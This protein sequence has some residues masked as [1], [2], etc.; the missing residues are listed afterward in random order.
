MVEGSEGTLSYEPKS[1]SESIAQRRADCYNTVLKSQHRQDGVLFTVITN[2]KTLSWSLCFTTHHGAVSYVPD[3]SPKTLST[4]NDPVAVVF[5]HNNPS[6]PRVPTREFETMPSPF[7]A[8]SQAK[9]RYEARR[10]TYFSAMI[11]SHIIQSAHMTAQR[12]VRLSARNAGETWY[13]QE[14]VRGRAS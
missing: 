11:E 6:G 2:T 5:S 8:Y 4:S 1:S 13:M 7:E 9:V 14:Q 10:A 3:L 12:N